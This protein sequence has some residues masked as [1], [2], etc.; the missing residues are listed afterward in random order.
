MTNTIS[1]DHQAVVDKYGF[2]A[3]FAEDGSFVVVDA[4]YR[5][6]NGGKG[7]RYVGKDVDATLTSAVTNHKAMTQ[8]AKAPSNETSLAWTPA[9]LTPQQKAAT[10][11]YGFVMT[12]DFGKVTI[13]D[14][15]V[16]KFKDASKKGVYTAA[17]VAE[18]LD[19]AIAVRKEYEASLVKPDKKAAAKAETKVAATPKPVAESR[20]KK[21]ATV[22]AD[23]EKPA[24]TKNAKKEKAKKEKEPRPA[25]DNRYMRASRIIAANPSITADQ[26]AKEATMSKSTAGHCLEAWKGVTAVLRE[27]NQLK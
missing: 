17:T 27:T 16:A 12:D 9:V 20:Q 4:A 2:E 11:K 13:T 23:D 6:A 18:A 8:T 24:E 3:S 19:A 1:T 26:L 10:T 15:V 21:A 14:P 22:K 7:G 5:R 25:K